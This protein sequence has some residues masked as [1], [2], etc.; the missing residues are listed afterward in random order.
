MSQQGRSGPLGGLFFGALFVAAGYIVAFYFGKPILDQAH[1]SKTWP[2]VSGTVTHSEVVTRRSKGK[3]QYS[4]KVAYRY[5]VEGRE[6]TCDNVWFGGHSSSNSSGSA[7]QTV[8]KYPTGAEI[9][10]FYE[11][12]N[13]A[14]AVLEPGTR[15]QSYLVFA[16]GVIFLAV[17]ILMVG[18]AFVDLLAAGVMFGTALVSL[19]RRES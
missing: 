6:F 18:G 13:P 17:G 12:S 9:A 7:S 15:W 14:N 5:A 4:S 16:I 10:V 1:A 8:K 11:P 3:V 19:S 2:S